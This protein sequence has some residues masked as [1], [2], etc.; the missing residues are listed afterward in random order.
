MV[1]DEN[2]ELGSRVD[3]R[4]HELIRRFVCPEGYCLK[5]DI[6]DNSSSHNLKY[7]KAETKFFTFSLFSIP[8]T[9]TNILKAIYCI[10]LSLEKT[11]PS[12]LLK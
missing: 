8:L 10:E 3:P 7:F 11:M 5:T 4:D 9:I 12:S 6:R 1:R 2:L